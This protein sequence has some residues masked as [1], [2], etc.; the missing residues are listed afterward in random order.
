MGHT[1]DQSADVISQPLPWAQPPQPCPRQCTGLTL[2][3]GNELDSLPPQEGLF[4][5]PSILSTPE[6]S[7]SIPPSLA[8]PISV[9][10]VPVLLSPA[11]KTKC[12]PT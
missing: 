12:S 3:P 4:L 9:P 7:L 11:P 5:V 8:R 6:N 1:Q 2:G 10:A